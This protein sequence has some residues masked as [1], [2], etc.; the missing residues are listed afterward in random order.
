MRIELDINDPSIEGED[1][2][3]E[4]DSIVLAIKELGVLIG[5]VDRSTAMTKYMGAKK[6]NLE[7][8]TGPIY[9]WDRKGRK[10][11]PN[12]EEQRNILMMKR[13]LDPTT[14]PPLSY[15]EVARR[16]NSLGFKGKKGGKWSSSAVRRTLRYIIHD[17]IHEFGKPD[18]WK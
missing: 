2:T 13:W 1:I 3:V 14:V 6:D 5:R 15:N 4:C 11:F 7:A 9:G 18:W 16:M 12:W 10:I 17:R 8:F